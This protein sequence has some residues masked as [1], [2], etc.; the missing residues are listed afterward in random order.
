MR[1]FNRD[2]QG[3]KEFA[4][5]SIVGVKDT[6]FLRRM[7]LDESLEEGVRIIMR[8][9]RI[10]KP[11]PETEL[12]AAASYIQSAIERRNE[13][14]SGVTPEM[15]AK[16][17]YLKDRTRNAAE[18][19]EFNQ[20]VSKI[21]F[22][23]PVLDGITKSYGQTAVLPV[24]GKKVRGMF[25]VK[26][27]GYDKQAIQRTQYRR[28]S[29]VWDNP[30]Q[31][32]DIT[33]ENLDAK[34]EEYQDTDERIFEINN[35]AVRI[36]P[37]IFKDHYVVIGLGN[38]TYK[39]KPYFCIQTKGSIIYF[40]DGK[41]LKRLGK[42]KIAEKRAQEYSHRT[43]EESKDFEKSLTFDPKSLYAM[44]TCGPTFPFIETLLDN[45]NRSQLQKPKKEGISY[46]D[47]FITFNRDGLYFQSQSDFQIPNFVA[48]VKPFN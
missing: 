7:H 43:L 34:M 15:R 38:K 41:L 13:E 6:D 9:L 22:S 18:T 39:N 8:D 46:D 19:I 42:S 31:A 29:T 5:G 14:I 47:L 26:T 20:L 36:A 45:P 28:V 16:F 44:T 40:C 17:R 37:E 27:S 48:I 1:L 21:F 4:D 25:E 24:D 10:G 30:G 35:S 11:L 32:L 33:L 23:N 12:R 2:I 3:V